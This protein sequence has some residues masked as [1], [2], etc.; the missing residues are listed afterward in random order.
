MEIFMKPLHM[1]EKRLDF[2]C[3]TRCGVATTDT[4]CRPGYTLT[5]F[6]V[7]AQSH[8]RKRQTMMIEIIVFWH[9]MKIFFF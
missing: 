4:V 9:D 5:V 2:Y 3:V 6:M 7:L 8:Q 1:M